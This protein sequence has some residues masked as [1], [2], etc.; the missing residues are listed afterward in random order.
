MA[1]FTHVPGRE[2]IREKPHERANRLDIIG[3]IAT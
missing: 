1:L 2:I 3:L